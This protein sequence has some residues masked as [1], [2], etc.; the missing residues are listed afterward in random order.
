MMNTPICDFIKKY[1]ESGSLRLHMPG[2]KGRVLTGPEPY[3]LTEIF[4]ADSLY[5]ANG[6]IRQSEQNA[7]KLFGSAMTLYSTE[8][9]SQCIRAM[10][11]LAL[12]HAKKKGERPLILSAR[13]AHKAFVVGAGMLDIDVEWISDSSDGY[14]SCKIDERELEDLLCELNPT[15]LYIT[16]PD[17]LG[18][19][20]DISAI[21][22][23]CRRHGVLLL[24]DNAHGA[25]LKFLSPSRH[26]LDA[27]ADLC[28]DS[29][30]KTLPA[31]TGAAYLH[32]S[33]SAPEWMRDA[34]RGALS[35][36]G[37]TSPSY[38]ILRSL[39]VVNAYVDG[40]YSE[41]L[42]DFSASAD[43]LKG[44]LSSVGY[45]LVGDEP[46]KLTLATKSY[47]YTGRELA[48]T[49][50]ENGIMCEFC[51]EDFLVLMLS[52]ELG[53]E[54]L[55]TLE[56]VLC[57]I[58]KRAPIKT[59]P[60]TTYLPQR[61]MRVREAMLSPSETISVSNAEGRILANLNISCP[62]AVPIAVC[63]ER[64]DKEVIS[65]FAYYGI[66]ECDVVADV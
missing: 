5:E 8:G 51:D 2:H 6:I 7:E 15:A 23:V 37:S 24:V 49:L 3:D 55:S 30:H 66:E 9:S 52:C 22:A 35:L 18:N 10:L 16:S 48:E 20:A 56:N 60:P 46:M 19:C 17:Y 28:C 63:G 26:P 54:C 4:G 57:S 45:T 25:Y 14:L 65:R 13:N 62:P 43:K 11:Y 47:G 33:G 1:A 50:A 42:R 64:I 53:E 61:V 27:G 29:A 21:S 12:M 31:L 32:I 59:A 36:F 44:R 38:L 34:A 39:D 40:G 41:R 58:E